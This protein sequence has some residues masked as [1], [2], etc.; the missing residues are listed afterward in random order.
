M[1][2]FL[3]KIASDLNKPNGLSLITPEQAPAFL[4]QLAIDRFHGIGAKTAQKMKQL[5][6][7]NGADLKAWSEG[8][9]SPNPAIGSFTSVRN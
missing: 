5:G 2:K 1:N 9:L 6:I 3:A 4:E 8:A 7:H